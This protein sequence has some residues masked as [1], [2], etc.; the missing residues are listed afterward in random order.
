MLNIMGKELAEEVKPRRAP[1]VRKVM[2]EER[3]PE[4]MEIYAD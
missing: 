3:K 2:V 1:K 4:V